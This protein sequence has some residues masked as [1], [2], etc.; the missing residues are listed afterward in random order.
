M[1]E[2]L[3]QES[4]LTLDR[5]IRRMET[6]T[7]TSVLSVA[8]PSGVQRFDYRD[9]ARN[10]QRLSATLRRWGIGSGDRVASL[11]FN[12]RQ[13]LELFLGVPVAGAVLHTVNPRL[14]S[15][16]LEF[17]LTHGGARLAFVDV[18]L[19]D[20]LAPVLGRIPNIEAI[21]ILEGGD[22][23]DTGYETFI[24]DTG[25]TT[26]AAP[27]LSEWQ[28]AGLCYTSGTTGLPKGVLYSHRSTFLHALS[29]C[30]VDV[31]GISR[32]DTVLPIVPLFHANGWGLPQAAGLSGANLVMPGRDLSG[33][34]VAG[35]I[36]SQRVT[37][38]SGVPTVLN[39]VL[40]FADQNPGVLETLTTIVSGG[41]P[42]MLPLVEGFEKHGVEVIQGW[43]MT[44]TSPNVSMS[45]PPRGVED[46]ERANAY[47]ISAGRLNPLVDARLIDG[48]GKELPWD[49]EA[50]GEIQLRSPH[51][52]SGYYLDAEA[53]KEKMDTGWL[54]TGDL[55]SI[56]SEGYVQ[57]RD[58]LKDLIKS[59]G[60]WIP[61][62]ELEHHIMSGPHVADVA[63]VARADER[64]G[65]RPIA[66]IVPLAGETLNE[67]A[68]REHLLARVP[69]WWMPNEFIV[70]S[71]LPLTSIG[72]VD[73]KL[74]RDQVNA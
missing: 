53:S 68:L 30:L 11:G 51:A 17:V 64:W 40:K 58:R 71:Q 61:T 46:R 50:A 4:P 15:E 35:L 14:S 67:L 16:H 29:T 34:A 56:D 48:Q 2:G 57:L 72:K 28:A 41:A 31:M 18:T 10:V 74:L 33:S 62:V 66:F 52:A 1:L 24:R 21:I 44:E 65:E 27:V 42:L 23:G 73:K 37:F 25:T 43:G 22:D 70:V 36:E 5:V 9:I 8:S 39:D 20:Q 63:V 3:M 32:L 59:G 6:T 54:R 69:R 7:G 13:H 12:T 60:E 47:R 55:A 19:A 49:G 26:P 38:A 45:R